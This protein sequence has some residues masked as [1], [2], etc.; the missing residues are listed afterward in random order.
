LAIVVEKSAA[1][2]LKISGTVY[3]QGV[4]PKYNAFRFGYASLQEDQLEKAVQILK[5]AID[6]I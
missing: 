1:M 4:N 2:G 6:K 5:T 3:S